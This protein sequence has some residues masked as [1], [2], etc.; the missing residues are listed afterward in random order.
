MYRWRGCKE[1]QMEPK[2]VLSAYKELRMTHQ[3]R[4]FGIIFRK[5]IDEIWPNSSRHKI[6]GFMSYAPLYEICKLLPPR[7]HVIK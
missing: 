5:K 6:P 7:H 1:L 4:I 3:A 2:Y